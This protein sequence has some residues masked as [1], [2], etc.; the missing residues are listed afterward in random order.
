MGHSAAV[1]IN[2]IKVFLE[3][4]IDNVKARSRILEGLHPGSTAPEGERLYSRRASAASK[5]AIIKQRTITVM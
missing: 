4:G 2:L 3:L 5:A 1:G